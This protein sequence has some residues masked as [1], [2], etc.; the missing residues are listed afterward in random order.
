MGNYREVARKQGDKTAT[1]GVA[2]FFI[3]K[4]YIFYYIKDRTA[5]TE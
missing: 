5:E 2:V 4:V 1:M 3:F